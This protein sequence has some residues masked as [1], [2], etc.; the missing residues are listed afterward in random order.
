[1]FARIAMCDINDERHQLLQ[2]IL[3]WGTL[4]IFAFSGWFVIPATTHYTYYDSK[5][6]GVL[7]K[8]L[9]SISKGPDEATPEAKNRGY[10]LLMFGI[11]GISFWL[12]II[13]FIANWRYEPSSK[14]FLK[15]WM[16]NSFAILLTVIFVFI[17]IDIVDLFG[18]I[19]DQ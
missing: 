14:Y 18:G 12:G 11:T 13:I 10:A 4:A 8:D 5:T 2:K 16:V 1:M 17:I 6:H 3:G 19:G 9:I 15:R 7:E